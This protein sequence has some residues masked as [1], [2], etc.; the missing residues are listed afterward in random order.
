MCTTGR[1]LLFNIMF[2]SF[3]FVLSLSFSLLFSLFRITV[4]Y[5]VGCPGPSCLGPSGYSYVFCP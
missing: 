5:F 1:K 4:L 3:I 2:F